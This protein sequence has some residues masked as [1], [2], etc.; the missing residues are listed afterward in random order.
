M[1]RNYQGSSVTATSL[2]ALP[3]SGVRGGGAASSQH[4]RSG[5]A[6]AGGHAEMQA[7]ERFMH[8]S[9]R[10]RMAAGRVE[11]IGFRDGQRRPAQ[12]RVCSLGPA[13]AS[14]A[15]DGATGGMLRLVART[16]RERRDESRDLVRSS[17][18]G[19]SSSRK[20]ARVPSRS[21]AQPRA[22]RRSGRPRRAGER[23]ESR[24][25]VER[26]GREERQTP[27]VHRPTQSGPIDS[28]LHR[29]PPASHRALAPRLSL[30]ISLILSARSIDSA[31]DPLSLLS[32]RCS[33]A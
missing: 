8:A 24:V 1:Q 4:M 21:A 26:C 30:R 6:S 23:A 3:A 17:R 15:D 33:S 12:P 20:R 27:G 16:M 10:G 29:A 7:S 31:A 14:G 28:A 22:R 19:G 9:A 32:P 18:H 11:W 2:S 5:C 25:D 13:E